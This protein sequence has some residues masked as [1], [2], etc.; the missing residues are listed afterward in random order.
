MNL[1]RMSVDELRRASRDLGA[2]VNELVADRPEAARIVA[3]G[4][5]MVCKELLTRAMGGDRELADRIHTLL[6]AGRE[7]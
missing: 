3:D 6:H 7:N 1:Y 4:L 5:E 2:L